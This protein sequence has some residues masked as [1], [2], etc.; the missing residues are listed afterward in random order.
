MNALAALTA[1]NALVYLAASTLHTGVKISLGAMTLGF[2]EP[3]PPAS[4]AEGIIGV[5][6]AIATVAL[7]RGYSLRLCWAAYIFALAGTLLGLSIILA[8]G[9]GGP[10][11]WVHFVMLAGLTGGF[12]LLAGA[13]RSARST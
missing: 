4:L 9:I 5:V 11:L 12:V 7:L 10:D 1:A 6:L 2:P 3:S 8:R 13:G